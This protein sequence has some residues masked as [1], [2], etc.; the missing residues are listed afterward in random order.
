MSAL[1]EV[2][3]LLGELSLADDPKKYLSDLRTLMASLD[4]NQ[5][6]KL[7]RGAE[8][9]ILFDSLNSSDGEQVEL[10]VDVLNYLLPLISSQEAVERF[11]DQLLRGLAH[12]NENVRHLA[13]KQVLQCAESENGMVTLITQ[14]S[15]LLAV[16]N[17]LGDSSQSI[18]KLAVNTLVALCGQQTGLNAVF[19]NECIT[20]LQ[21]I[22][23]K[24]D[25]AR[26]NVYECIVKI[27]LLGD[28]ALGMVSNSGLL[29]RLTAEV[30][31]GDV[32][33]QLNALELL[34]P[35]AQS[36]SGMKHL[37]EGGVISKLQYLLSLAEADPMAAMLMPGLVKFFG[38]MGQCRPQQ[39]V[40]E[41]SSVMLMILRLASGTM[42]LGDPILQ[43]V[44]IETVAHIGATAEGKSALGKFKTEM[45]EV[46][47]MLGTKIR[48]APS[49][50]RV[51]VLDA[52]S[53]LFFLNLE[54]HTEELLQLLELWW[55]GVGG[56]SL[57][58]VIA[59][60]R[61]PFMDLH[62]TAL[63][64]LNSLASM[65]W[66][67][68]L[69]FTEPGLI[70]YILDR[71]TES[72]KEGMEAKW[73]IVGTLVK[74]HTSAFPYPEGYVGKLTKYYNEGPFFV[75]ACMEVAVE[76]EQ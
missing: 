67:Q 16:I 27:S 28:M 46:L 49:D 69:I 31:T 74:S 7:L 75:E 38:N 13:I 48:M 40:D 43:I 73:N 50:Q 37:L 72:V 30:T 70:E 59:V 71:S 65:P 5:Q 47:D 35:L 18:V 19:S 11:G 56:V 42:D 14:H 21:N 25:S 29:D 60:A 22:M 34:I 26:F 57:E 44:A 24:S 52:L 6:L 4:P 1:D 2:V 39:M 66:G 51:R 10:C 9:N 53:Q 20:N 45:D 63:E 54:D 58:K 3:R 15:L 17:S 23:T 55:A 68:R 62:C 12:P 76:G 36:P 8:L 61:Q 41:F 64:L 32:L 33:T